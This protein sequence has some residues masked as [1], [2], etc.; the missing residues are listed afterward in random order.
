MEGKHTFGFFLKIFKK[1]GRQHLPTKPQKVQRKRQSK[2]QHTKPKK[3][4]SEKKR[5]RGR[6]GQERRERILNRD[7]CICR[8]CS[9]P[10][11][12]NELIVDHIIPLFEGGADKD[13]NLQLLCLHHNAI[14]TRK[15]LQRYK[16]YHHPS[17]RQ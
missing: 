9:K 6:R 4:S 14:K 12:K 16:K 3:L 15:E 13:D 8:H 5:L 7:S 10:F 2:K 17:V 1:Y 11:P